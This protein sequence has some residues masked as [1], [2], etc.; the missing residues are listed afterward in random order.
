M[1]K[2]I[3][4]LILI[5]SCWSNKKYEDGHIK[6]KSVANSDNEQQSLFKNIHST[7]GKFSLED[8]NSGLAL[9]FGKKDQ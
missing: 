5:T 7:S 6:I 3:F 1:K 2:Y 9:V 4:I 8:L